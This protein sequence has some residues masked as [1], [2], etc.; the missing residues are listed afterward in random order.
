MDENIFEIKDVQLK[1]EER[2][3]CEVWC[4]CMGYFRRVADFNKG[5]KS[6]FYER[7]NFSEDKCRCHLDQELENMAIAA[8]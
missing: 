2:Q 7:V 6:E 1:D 8:E 4:R 5:K 3:K